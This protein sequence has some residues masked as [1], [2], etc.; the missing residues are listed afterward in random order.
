[1]NEAIIFS[2]L[3]FSGYDALGYKHI[4]GIK[5]AGVIPI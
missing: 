4:D 5:K 2:P 1:M 3:Q